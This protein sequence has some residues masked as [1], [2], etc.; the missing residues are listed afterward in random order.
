MKIKILGPAFLAAGVLI[1]G[2]AA[3]ADQI[4]LVH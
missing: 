3:N 1:Y 4:T 2:P